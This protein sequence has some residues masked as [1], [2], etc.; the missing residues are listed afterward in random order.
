[1]LDVDGGKD[2]NTRFQQFFNILPAFR[3][4]RAWRITVRQFV[5][6]NNRRATGQRRVE[7]ELAEMASVTRLPF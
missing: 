4:A 5:H 6:E 7:I 3:V 2:V 1:M